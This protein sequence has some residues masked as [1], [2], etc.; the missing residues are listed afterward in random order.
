MTFS[1]IK[2]VTREIFLSGH[3]RHVTESS[4]VRICTTTL[5]W[6]HLIFLICR[7]L[8]CG[9]KRLM[10]TRKGSRDVVLRPTKFAEVGSVCVGPNDKST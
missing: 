1:S 9:S 8:T 5:F 6:T 2:R 7:R 10:V 3:D 4:C